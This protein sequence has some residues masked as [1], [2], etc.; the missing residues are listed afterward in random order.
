MRMLGRD[1]RRTAILVTAWLAIAGCQTAY[2]RTMEKLGY[3]KRD[4]LVNRVHD[5]RDAQVQ[6]KK[7]FESAL[8]QFIAVTSFDGG[9]LD[10]EY[11]KL[12]SG[13]EESEARARTVRRRIADVER[14]A[15]DLFAEWE[16][17]LDEYT[18][19]DLRRASQR[20]L[21]QTR[22][23]Y[24]QLMKAMRDAEAKIDPVLA[25]FRDRLLFLKHNLN[26]QAIASLRT[27][28]RAIETEIRELIRDMDESI[29]EAD[30]FIKAMASD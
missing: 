17:E 26:A 16:R 5:A 20:Q 18:N 25:A 12:K 13:H 4:L 3:E 27:E 29:E 8:E 21:E 11:R 14:V 15:S 9:E 28:R 24:R 19:R 7:Q 10:Q 2:Y 22:G 30:R 1:S 23:R 6:A